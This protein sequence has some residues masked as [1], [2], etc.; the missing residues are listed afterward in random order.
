MTLLLRR[1]AVA[2]DRPPA[3]RGGEAERR[4]SDHPRLAAAYVPRLPFA[5]SG[6]S[7]L[8]RKNEL[9]REDAIA[10]EVRRSGVG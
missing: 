6:E 4:R 5:E 10:L 2:F 8:V 7:T 9:P 1:R 3:G